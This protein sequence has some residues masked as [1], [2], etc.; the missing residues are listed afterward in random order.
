MADAEDD[1]PEELDCS[2]QK[3]ANKYSEAGKIAEQV[4]QEV[5]A[6][7]KDCNSVLEL[8]K[9]GDERIT[10]LTSSK[11][12]NLPRGVAFPTCISKN[13]IAGHFQPIDPET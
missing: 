3:T 5:I 1:Q 11:F 4:L 2:D 6:K 9:F 7:A 13:E 10:E 12:T 8:C